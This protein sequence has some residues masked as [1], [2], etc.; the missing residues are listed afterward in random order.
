[1]TSF[2]SI[3]DELHGDT[4]RADIPIRAIYPSVIYSTMNGEEQPLEFNLVL[5]VAA[6]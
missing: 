2:I 4:A 3:Y 6:G 1:M 5:P